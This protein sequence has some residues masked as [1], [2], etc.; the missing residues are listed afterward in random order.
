MAVLKIERITKRFGGITALDQVSFSVARNELV[1]LIGPNGSGKTTLF[2]CVAGEL[3]P[4]SGT[5]YING[6]NTSGWPVNQIA[7]LGL[8]R[9]YQQIEVFPKL[10]VRENLF[11]AGQEAH[12]IG[13][14]ESLWKSR[15]VKAL[16]TRLEEETEA[17]IEMLGLMDQAEEY[18]GDLSYG[19]RKILAIGMALMSKPE[20]LL[21]DEPVAAVNPTMISK[22][23]KILMDIKARGFTILI[24]EHN[25]PV[26]MEIAERI[27]VVNS[28]KKLL[29]GPP[30]VI[31][32]DQRVIE[33]YFGG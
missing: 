7:R 29:E 5:I 24:V 10:T 32:K 13:L 17:M 15:K 21:L 14:V 23:I 20:I 28:G 26:V 31:R 3:R 12:K 2:N 19:Q 9:T 4:D 33:A 8:S 18:G 6:I 16:D 27:V 1:A 22:I 11:V 30:E 25:L